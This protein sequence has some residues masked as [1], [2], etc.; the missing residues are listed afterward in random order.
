[1]N[2]FWK[3]PELAV[4]KLMIIF[5]KISEQK[6]FIILGH[7]CIVEF[8]IHFLKA[9]FDLRIGYFEALLGIPWQEMGA[10]DGQLNGLQELVESMDEEHFRKM[11]VGE[12]A[13]AKGNVEERFD[14][15]ITRYSLDLEFPIVYRGG[16]IV[17]YKITHPTD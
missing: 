7:H 10:T 17:A 9:D 11:P 4:P 14:Y 16:N 1:M 5:R 15:F 2:I 6:V 3:I 13:F 12:T 8:S